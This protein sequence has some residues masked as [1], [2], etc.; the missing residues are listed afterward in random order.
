M[1]GRA[2]T[3]DGRLVDPLNFC[4]EDVSIGHIAHRLAQTCR[5]SGSTR[6]FACARKSG[7]TIR[8]FYSVAQHSHEVAMRVDRRDRLKGLLHDSP[9]AYTADIPGP[10]KHKVAIDG[11]PFLEVEREILLVIFEA[12][13][14]SVADPLLPR[15]VF[16]ADAQML[17]T[18]ARDFMP[19]HEVW[20]S[21]GYAKPYGGKLVSWW[22]PDAELHFLRL[23]HELTSDRFLGGV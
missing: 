4:A 6:A 9:E 10:W 16:E 17:A 7:P 21:D 15:S 14:L 3:S 23:F 11:V 2:M 20:E 19:A 22:P 1:D 13:G 5:F 8:D 18:E 12:F